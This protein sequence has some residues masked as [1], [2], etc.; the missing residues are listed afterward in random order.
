MDF[1][2][3]ERLITKDTDAVDKPRY[4]AR[5]FKVLTRE[6]ASPDVERIIKETQE[7]EVESAFWHKRAVPTRDAPQSAP[8]FYIHQP[9]ACVASG[10]G[11]RCEAV[12]RVIFSA[13]LRQEERDEER[14]GESNA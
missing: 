6:T 11:V 8:P 9:L 7:M 1:A 5:S 14:E 2:A 4:S 13:V 10:A 3:G 12:F